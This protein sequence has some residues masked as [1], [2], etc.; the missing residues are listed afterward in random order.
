MHCNHSHYDHHHNESAANLSILPFSPI[1]SLF[2]AFMEDNVNISFS[3]SN[4]SHNHT[5]HHGHAKLSG[6]PSW[7]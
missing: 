4:T 2:D 3:L 6:Q 1:S 5:A 7:T